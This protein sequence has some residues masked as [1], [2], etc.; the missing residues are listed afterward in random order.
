MPSLVLRCR[1]LLSSARRLAAVFLIVGLLPATPAVAAEATTGAIY[2]TVLDQDGHPLAR[3]TVSA[4]SPSGSYAVTTDAQGRFAILGV[5]PDSYTIS[6]EKQ[7]F[8]SVSRLGV[9]VLPGE[10]QQTEFTLAEQLLTIGHVSAGSTAFEPGSPSDTFTVSKTAATALSPAAS[11]SGL[12]TYLSGTVQG[13]IAS[14]P[15]V[16]LDPFANAILR[17]GKAADATFDYDSVPIPQ[18]LIAEPGGNIVGAQLP[19]TGIA[20]VTATLAGY[21][22]QGANSLGGVINQVPAVGTYPGRA[23]LAL[24]DGLSGGQYQNDSLE[25]LGA[26]PDRRLRYAFASTVGSQYFSY[27]DGSTFYPSEAAT[28]GLALQTRGEYSLES[29][30]HYQV[31][32]KDDISLLGLAG[33]ATYNQYDSPYAGETVGTFDGATMTFPGETNPNAPVNYAS[34]IRGSYDILTAQWLHS[35]EHSLSRV[36]LYQSQTGSSAGGPF[37]DENGWPDGSISLSQ[38]Q[39]ARE[40]GLGYD[41]EDFLGGRHDLRFGAEYRTNTSFLDQVVPT[42]DEHISSRPTLISYL[43]Y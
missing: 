36:Q 19:T 29:N 42:A 16:I 26:T 39:G 22:S 11:S 18:G 34:G 2:G 6:A 40:E 15:G 31:N 10:R 17:G 21:T 37:W 8:R 3:V 14:L 23:T 35:G 30:I 25:I 20:S 43:A 27:G 33:Q 4:A 32:S 12:S 41:G 7:G 1:K 9:N 13:A 5:V 38:T 28:Y 24:A